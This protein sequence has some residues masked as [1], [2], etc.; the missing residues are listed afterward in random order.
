ML[1][2][3]TLLA[4]SAATLAAP[5]TLTEARAATP[6]GVAVMAKQIDDIVSFDPAESYEFTNGEVDANCY[7]R[8]IKPNLDDATK[9]E[10]DLAETWDVSPDG[11]TY[12]FRLRRD[13]KFESGNPVTAHDAA[14]SLQRVVK[15]NKTPGFIITQFGFNPDNVE[16]AIRALDDTTVELKLPNEAEATSFVL[17][18]LSANVGSVVDMK[19]VMA[20]QTNGDLGNAWL[21]SRTAGAGAYKLTEWAASD[22][23]IIDA[24]PNAAEKGNMR[25]IV[26]RHIADPAAQLLLLQKGDVDIARELGSDQLKSIAGDKDLTVSSAPQGTSMYLAMN[27]AMPE[28]QKAQVHQAIKW[29]IDYDAIARNITPGTWSVCQAFLPDALPGALKSN[30]FRKDV[31]KAKQLLSEAGLASGFA[32]TMDYISASPH[33]EIAQ[34]LQADLAAIGIKVTL[35]P[36]E[37]KQVITKTRARQHQLALLY[38]GTDYFDPNSNCQAWC[39]NPDDSDQSKLKILAWRSHFVDKQLTSESQAAVHELDPT[40]RMALYRTIQQ[41]FMDRAPFAMLLQR[42]AVAVLGKGVSGF[43]VGPMPDYTHYTTIAKA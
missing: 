3:R 17:Y 2:R 34:A 16:Q 1:S 35:Q 23:V 39:E 29:A 30:P 22:H 36:G 33:A 32:V 31:A 24:N 14:F 11:L 26:M 41:Q 15:L 21:K 18:C 8:L 12:T 10:G 19:T 42:N 20:N 13:A 38:W 43:K 28:L 25:R 5:A 37:Q 6:K 4:G 9:I 40:E 7:R 27:Q